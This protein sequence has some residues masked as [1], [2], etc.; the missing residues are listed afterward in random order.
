MPPDRCSRKDLN[1]TECG[2]GFPGP[3][4]CVIPAYNEE[5]HIADVL[6]VIC[7]VPGLQRIVVVDDASRD[8]TGAVVLSYG[9]CD[10]RV[11]LLHLSRNRGKGGAM[12]A[13]ADASGCDV[14]VF[15]D[16]DLVGLR[17]EH[18]LSLIQPVCA[19]ACSMA[20][21]LF[22]EGRV[23]TDWSHRVTP[24]LSGQRCLRWSLF[25]STPDLAAARY[26]AEV[27]L[28]LHAFSGR[29]KVATVPWPGV[30]HVMKVERA[31]WLQ[32]CISYL[33]M[34]RQII[35]YLW[36][37]LG[38]RWPLRRIRVRRAPEGM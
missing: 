19:D 31:G 17:P 30:T 29:H 35:A 21:G 1:G 7:R 9:E 32:G 36:V 24:F 12:V 23:W 3:V 14:I 2:I 6:G 4:A 18:V 38:Y 27:A 33:S 10:P 20:V 16:A 5:P 26:G 13:G 34:Y 22:E 15:L 28:S 25:R 11:R 37:H 8:N